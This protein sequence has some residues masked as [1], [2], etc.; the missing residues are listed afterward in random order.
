M[1]FHSLGATTRLKEFLRGEHVNHISS[2]AF[3]PVAVEYQTQGFAFN[4]KVAE[5]ST[6]YRVVKILLTF[7]LILCQLN[8][9]DIWGSFRFAASILSFIVLFM[10]KWLFSP[11]PSLI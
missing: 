4:L 9:P 7:L 11:F 2:E 8:L 10:P 6:R 3:S 1:S 5:S